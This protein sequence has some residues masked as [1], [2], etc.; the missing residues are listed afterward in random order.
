MAEFVLIIHDVADY[1]AWKSVF[2]GAAALRATAGERRFQVLTD[3]LDGNRIVHFSQWTSL[4]AAQRF[5]GSPELAEIRKV[6]GVK[7]PEFHYL[8]QRDAG[9]LPASALIAEAIHDL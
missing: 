3:H 2:D 8:T 5:F 1:D 7:A 9:D 6:A 4:D